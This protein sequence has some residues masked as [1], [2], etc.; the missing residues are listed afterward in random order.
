MNEGECACV[1]SHLNAIEYFVNETDLD[2]IVIMEDDVEIQ[3][4]A[5]WNF[6]W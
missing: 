6:T 5:Y 4:A 2:E 1:M 3:Q